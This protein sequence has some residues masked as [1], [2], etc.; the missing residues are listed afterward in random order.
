MTQIM[1]PKFIKYNEHFEIR[2]HEAVQARLD[3]LFHK[4]KIIRFF[5]Q[6]IK[7]LHQKEEKLDFYIM[8][9][10]ITGKSFT[11]ATRFLYEED[12]VLGMLEKYGLA[13]I[14]DMVFTRR[15][16][17]YCWI[18]SQAVRNSKSPEEILAYLDEYYN[19]DNNQDEKKLQLAKKILTLM[20]EKSVNTAIETTKKQIRED[21]KLI[22]KFFIARCQR[23]KIRLPYI[24]G[25]NWLAG[26]EEPSKEMLEFLQ[27]LIRI[28]DK[29]DSIICINPAG[30]QMLV[31]N[32]VFYE[33]SWS[34]EHLLEDF[35]ALKVPAVTIFSQYKIDLSKYHI[36][37]DVL[38]FDLF[39]ERISLTH[40]VP[41]FNTENKEKNL[42]RCSDKETRKDFFDLLHKMQET[43]R[44]ELRF[45]NARLIKILQE[46]T[47]D[48]L[49]RI[50]SPQLMS[51]LNAGEKYYEWQQ[52]TPK[53]DEELQKWLA[54]ENLLDKLND[55]A[56][57]SV[58]KEIY[59]HYFRYPDTNAFLPW[60]EQHMGEFIRESLDKQPLG[61]IMILYDHY[62]FN[63]KNANVL[64]ALY[65]FFSNPEGFKEYQ[66]FSMAERAKHHNLGQLPPTT[67]DAS[68]I[69][70]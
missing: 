47:A 9:G 14:Y 38:A 24:F 57:L 50:F 33:N 62:K 3:W 22:I 46:A 63:N 65:A 40:A 21:K 25:T 19:R 44:S 5:Q 7:E 59:Y 48:F 10:N 29:K 56:S 58:L 17:G 35:P 15:F 52:A 69:M 70:R 42:R 37:G 27:I 51:Y 18:S 12:K 26:N 34:I 39:F 23:E 8:L 66:N 64:F 16:K 6:H 60:D 36:Y 67:R 20:D 30:R 4:D 13:D 61:N 32:A 55:G 53:C 43:R 31:N 49:P 45:R 68:A 2:F 28:Y 41:R 54:A 1:L 11:E